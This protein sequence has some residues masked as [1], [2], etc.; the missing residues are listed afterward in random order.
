M[1]IALYILTPV[2]M[3]TMVSCGDDEQDQEV[4][5]IED[6][7]GDVGEMEVDSS[8][9][10]SADQM[11]LDNDFARFVFSQM[12]EYDTLTLDDRHLMD[13]FNFS[14]RKRIR[15][16]GKEDV[17]YGRNGKATPDVKLYYYTFPDSVKT[18]NALYNYLDGMAA[19][20]EGGPV[21]MLEDVDA[22]KMPPMQMFVYDT[23]IVSVHYTTE[24]EKG[25]DWSPF[26]DSLVY[27]FGDNYRYRFD[28]ESGGP[29]IWEK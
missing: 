12:D 13:R 24:A 3:L 21:K 22:I 26:K 17:P 9:E 11:V 19:E 18:N 4:V 16:K 5:D 6:I 28:V 2:L 1:R 15:F 20:G 23:V 10:E 8:G 29:L 14:S 27:N 25:N 7:M